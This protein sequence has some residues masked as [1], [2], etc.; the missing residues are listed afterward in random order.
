[1]SYKGKLE[2]IIETIYKKNNY[3]LD[4]EVKEVLLDDS[5][6]LLLSAPAG[7]TKTTLTQLIV[8]LVKL[9]RMIQGVKHNKK[10][11]SPR[12]RIPTTI[13]QSRI[14]CL[15][16][17]K[18]NAGDIDTVHARFYNMLTQLKYTS[19]SPAAVN[20]VE[21]GVYAT[22]LHS[23]ANE[24]IKNNL[25]VLKLREFNLS[26]EEN[27]KANFAAV[28]T[29]VMEQSSVAVTNTL[30]NEVKTLY[31]LYVGLKLYETPEDKPLTD[32]VQFELAMQST[33]V[34]SKYL[35]EIFVS[36]DKRKKLLKLNEF[37]DM[38]RL[39]DDL[40][41]IPEIRESYKTKFDI[42]VADEVQD[43]TPLMF[44]I[45][46]TLVGPNTRT[47]TVGDGDQSIYSFLGA[48]EDAIGNFEN[49]MGYEPKRYN[50]TVNR[51]CRKDTMPFALNVINSISTR[52]P[53][54]IK[55]TKLGG[56]LNRIEYKDVPEQLLAIE[57]IMK[58]K[59]TGNMGILF[60]NKNQSIILSRYLYER[61]I[62]AN[63]IN[64]YNCM[65][66]RIYTLFL[67]V[68]K[69]CFISKSQNGLRLLNR[70][71]P[72][73]KQ[74]LED[75]F[76][77][78]PKTKISKTC[79][80]S[81]LWGNLDF[82]PLYQ[83]SKSYFS[84]NE[85]VE[86]VKKVAKESHSIIASDC[87]ERLLDLFYKNYF[88]HLTEAQ[89]DPFVEM[90]LSWAKR[91]LSVGYNLATAVDNLQ[92]NIYKYMGSG[93]KVGKLNICTIHGTKGLEFNHVILNLEKDKVPPGLVLSP[94]AQKFQDDEENR[95]FYVGGTRQID[96]LTVLCNM[97]SPHRLAD[98]SYFQSDEPII[99][100]PKFSGEKPKIL[101]DD[102]L[103]KAAPV[104]GRRSLL[105][106]D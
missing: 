31:D 102:L 37:S 36:Y 104:R 62:T 15:V 43:F 34:P 90:V 20:Y 22:T 6:H 3:I 88:S 41:K 51:R 55:T 25:A 50:L 42:I 92:K 4:N 100:E 46:K 8:N 45:Y 81:Q 85:Q 99:I 87:I 68:L 73:R 57:K 67:E 94:K 21:P 70:L 78:D 80:T 12:D 2:G 79:P 91:D 14:L 97:Q 86:F 23:Y 98:E 77:F 101:Q 60:R 19:P 17:N 59:V 56:E 89:E 95:L 38:L 7:G 69:E 29:K 75:F 33:Q 5:Q 32:S 48:V 18:H 27:I 58:E 28:V 72:F 83:D 35:R 40:L 30:I 96:S 9:D 93:R 52:A 54:E 82:T 103:S 76:Q 53:R 47:V 13:S 105:L 26:K 61:G 1:M 74:A 66:H 39:A 63:Y 10:V 84:I 106:E 71:L 44:S 11:N 49:I 24:I 64:A 65:Q 16:Y